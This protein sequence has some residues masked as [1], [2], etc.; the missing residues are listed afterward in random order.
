MRERT[1]VPETRKIALV[2]LPGN[3]SK[4]VISGGSNHYCSCQQMGLS[5]SGIFNCSS[6]VWKL[7]EGRKKCSSFYLWE[8]SRSWVAWIFLRLYPEWIVVVCSTWYLN[9]AIWHLFELLTSEYEYQFEQFGSFISLNNKYSTY[10]DKDSVSERGRWPGSLF[11]VAWLRFENSLSNRNSS[12][13]GC[14]RLSSSSSGFCPVDSFCE[15]Q[16]TDN[17]IGDVAGPVNRNPPWKSI[18]RRPP[19]LLTL[20]NPLLTTINSLLWERMGFEFNDLSIAGCA[21]TIGISW[22]LQNEHAVGEEDDDLMALAVGPQPY[23][24]SVL[25]V[26]WING[27]VED[28]VGHHMWYVCYTAP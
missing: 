4:I 5:T 3:I 24:S 28:N 25:P 11:K 7:K 19:L 27:A 21:L 9:V 17:E 2:R 6:L 13:T 26:F 12:S 8:V 20:D 15:T 10:W 14:N 22:L 23:L 1:V 16:Q 18:G